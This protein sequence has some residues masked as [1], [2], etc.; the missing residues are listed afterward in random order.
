MA[1]AIVDLTDVTGDSVIVVIAHISHIT[2]LSPRESTIHLAG[3]KGV[4][5]NGTLYELVEKIWPKAVS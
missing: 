3:G 4:R 5:V 2:V 1:K